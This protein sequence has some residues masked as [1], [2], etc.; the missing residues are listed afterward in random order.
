MNEFEYEIKSDEDEA[1]NKSLQ[2]ENFSMETQNM[3]QRES[4]DGFRAE[5]G[6]LITRNLQTSYSLFLGTSGQKG[7]SYQFGPSYQKL[8]GRTLILG[9]INDEGT[10]SG[11]ISKM[12]GEKVEG[13]VSVSSSL[14]DES[15]N[16]G[17]VSV[18]YNGSESSYSFKAAYQGILLLNGLFS[19]VI[20]N[21]LQLGGELT[22]I[23]ANDS[24]I[25]SLGS[26]YCLGKN[27]F[28][29]Q[30]TR[31]PDFTNIGRIFR[32]IHTIKSSFYRKVSNRLSLG[33]EVEVSVPSYDSVLRF[34]Y[35]YLFKTA[36]IQGM[37]DTSGK[38]SLQC[39]DSKGFG[40]SGTLDYIR[41]DYKFGFMMHFFPNEREDSLDD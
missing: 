40:I 38:V 37:I 26:R 18:D 23:T 17:E 35:D 34:G 39:Q 41:N 36:R 3:F 33:S 25:M 10:V 31:Q 2:F 32:N 1:T 28:Y 19:Q 27:V 22:W 5:F 7:Y 21:R 6:K 14:S 11:R 24:S 4:F 8:S 30:I 15:R 12:F 9:R 20:T 29:N 13:R 16:M